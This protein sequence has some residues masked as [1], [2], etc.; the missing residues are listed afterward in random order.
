MQHRTLLMQESMTIKGT[1]CHLHPKSRV[2]PPSPLS[3]A[4]LTPNRKRGENENQLTYN[5]KCSTWN[6]L[7][8]AAQNGNCSTWN[9][10]NPAQNRRDPRLAHRPNTTIP[11]LTFRPKSRK[12]STEGVFLQ[13]TRKLP[14][15]SLQTPSS[16]EVCWIF[17]SPGR[18]SFPQ[19]GGVLHSQR[20]YPRRALPFTLDSHG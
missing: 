5:A 19:I 16:T 8:N 20:S 13:Q 11:P 7:G 4:A 3:I 12:F 1:L 9:I 17:A 6:N 10:S 2:F 14:R 18:S 15:T